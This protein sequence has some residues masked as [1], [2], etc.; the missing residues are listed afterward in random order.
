ME[1]DYTY[2]ITRDGNKILLKDLTNHHLINIVSM[3]QKNKPNT[4]KKYPHKTNKKYLLYIRFDENTD[5]D[6]LVKVNNF[7][8]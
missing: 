2:W 4:N 1:K 3:L 5:F 6:Q 8:I 7:S